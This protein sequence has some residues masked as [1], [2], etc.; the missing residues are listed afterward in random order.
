MSVPTPRMIGGN[1]RVIGQR[2]GGRHGRTVK[3]WIAR[4]EFPRPDLVINNRPYWYE[5]TLTEFD[6]QRVAAALSGSRVRQPADQQSK[7]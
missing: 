7:T 3:R 2:Y 6:R 5:T 1:H 4:G